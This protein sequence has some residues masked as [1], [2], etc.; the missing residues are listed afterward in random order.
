MLPDQQQYKP[1][2]LTRWKV[3]ESWRWKKHIKQWLKKIE[4]VFSL[5]KKRKNRDRVN[6]FQNFQKKV[7]NESKTPVW[8]AT[9]FC[10][11]VILK[12]EEYDAAPVQVRFCCYSKFYCYQ[13]LPFK[14]FN[15]FLTFFY[16]TTLNLSFCPVYNPSLTVVVNSRR[17]SGLICPGLY[18]LFCLDSGWSWAH[19]LHCSKHINTPQPLVPQYRASNVAANILVTF[20]KSVH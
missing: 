12:Y 6:L 15:Q 8:W 3:R 2:I 14:H 9:A 16:S 11:S 1:L 18:L 19:R 4:K 20:Q 5:K 7:K 17:D 10:C 13:S